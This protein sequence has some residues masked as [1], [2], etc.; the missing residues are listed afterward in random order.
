MFI[1][2]AKNT[3]HFIYLLVSSEKETFVLH[4][5]KPFFLS[6]LLSALLEAQTTS[7]FT[8]TMLLS[9]LSSVWI[10][11]RASLAFWTWFRSAAV[12]EGDS[13]RV[14]YVSLKGNLKPLKILSWKGFIT[15][16]LNVLCYTICL[17]LRFWKHNLLLGHDLIPRCFWI[18]IK[19]DL[20]SIFT[21]TE[22][23]TDPT[24]YTQN[25]NTNVS[26]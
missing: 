25:G 6:N 16:D 22:Q 3:F 8:G 14:T 21:F 24:K 13:L 9:T 17:L 10:H 23:K 20:I 12:F 19:N 11:L 18:Q 26:E 4:F 1:C 5:L 2:L 7:W 15:T